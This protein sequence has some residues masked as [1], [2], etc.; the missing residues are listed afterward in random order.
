[1][2]ARN[3]IQTAG[4]LYL[5]PVPIGN[6]GDITL[7]ALEVLS[8][9]ELIAAE[10]TRTT[11]FLLNHHKIAYQEIISYH[12]FNE[13]ARVNLLIEHLR[14]GKDLAVVS[15]AGTPALSDPASILVD[16]AIEANINVIA[17]PGA[18]ALLPAL[19]ASGLNDGP[20]LYLG[21][22]PTKAKLRNQVLEQIK[23]SHYPVV[24]YEA[25]HRIE[26]L[27]AELEQALGDRRVC[28]AREITKLHEEYIRGTLK[29]LKEPGKIKAKGEFVVVIDKAPEADEPNTAQVE[30]L[31][32]LLKKEQI[33]ISAATKILMQ[34]TGIKRNQAYQLLLDNEHEAE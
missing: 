1:M 25:P 14:S 32:A 9:V 34:V 26:K 21:F 24:L 7:R 20:F 8:N 11:S 28:L 31:V 29:E 2:K 4:N 6:L 27:M 12:K 3:E 10:D 15:D 30:Q 22:L 23:A 19:T 33:S 13:R 17:L 16:A 18:S 5:V